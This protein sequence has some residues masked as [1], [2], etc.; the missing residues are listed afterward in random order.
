MKE[1]TENKGQVAASKPLRV[2]VA[3]DDDLARTLI[4]QALG[5]FED[6]EVVA[7]AQNGSEV[8]NLVNAHRV[9]IVLMD[10]DM[11]R[12]DG[13]EATRWLAKEHPE[14]K[15]LV[16]TAFERRPSVM[17]AIQAGA[18]GFITKDTPPVEIAEDL[19]RVA[20]G[21]SVISQNP[22]EAMFEMVRA[23]P[24]EAKPD[25]EFRVAVEG[26]P[27]QQRKVYGLLVEGLSNQQIAKQMGLKEITARDYVSQILAKTGCESRSEV[28]V[29]AFENGITA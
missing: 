20:R 5:A 15:V 7:V 14:I 17:E 12:M 25:P 28:V 21:E 29:R 11:P 18:V 4:P 10:V 2:L 13:I 9:D 1:K 23:Q 8:L 6:I 16:F 27:K 19:R 3:D 24:L 26:L 22:A